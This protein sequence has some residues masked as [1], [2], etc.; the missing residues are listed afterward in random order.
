MSKQKLIETV[1][2]ILKI[3]DEQVDLCFLSKLEEKEIETLIAY[4]RD[5]VERMQQ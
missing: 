3:D 1:Q 2:R 4:I 5:R